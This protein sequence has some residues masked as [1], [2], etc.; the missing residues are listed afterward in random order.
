MPITWASPRA[1]S[2]PSDNA[3]LWRWDNTDPFGNNAA[4]ENPAGLGTFKYELRFPGQ[5]YD[6]E[7]G[8]HYN[9]FRDYDP[10]IGRYAQSDPAGLYGGLNTYGYVG[11]GPLS[12]VDPQGLFSPD[13]HYLMTLAAM[14]SISCSKLS[15]F[16]LA[17][18]TMWVDFENG[19]QDPEDSYRHSMCMPGEGRWPHSPSFRDNYIPY[20]VGSCTQKGLANGLH[21]VQDGFAAGHKKECWNG[22]FPGLSHLLHDFVPTPAE[23]SAAIEASKRLIQD[24]VR[25]CNCCS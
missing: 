1:I 15:R 20:N 11:A 4:N 24:F 13:Q 6:A 16:G 10:A 7:T 14:A 8:T 19:S 2:R 21:A 3:L 22:G 18:D 5:Y 23:C 9:Y 17:W 25:R 12:R